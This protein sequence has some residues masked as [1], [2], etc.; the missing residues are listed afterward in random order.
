M[1]GPFAAPTKSADGFGPK[2][3]ARPT[4]TSA[5]PQGALVLLPMG[6]PLLSRSSPDACGD[7]IRRSAAPSGPGRPDST[8]VAVG[9]IRLNGGVYPLVHECHDCRRA[10]LDLDLPGAEQE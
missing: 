1:L 10:G 7:R 9:T 5:S 6:P 3:V 4:R 2:G 8:R